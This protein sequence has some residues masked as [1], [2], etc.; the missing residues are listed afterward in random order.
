MAEQDATPAEEL[1]DLQIT[2][3]VGLGGGDALPLAAKP[4]W[5]VAQ[6]IHEAQALLKE[7]HAR[8]DVVHAGNVLPSD[9]TLEAAGL[10]DGSEV[11]LI[12]SRWQRGLR[13]RCLSSKR[14]PA[15]LGT[16]VGIFE[17]VPQIILDKSLLVP[18]TLEDFLTVEPTGETVPT[19]QE[20]VTKATKDLTGVNG[21]TSVDDDAPVRIREVSLGEC[22]R[23]RSPDLPSAS[24]EGW[25]T[26]MVKG[27]HPVRL[28]DAQDKFEFDATGFIYDQI[29]DDDGKEARVFIWD[30]HKGTADDLEVLELLTDSD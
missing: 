17:N 30:M 16:I 4:L 26:C 5:T 1:P 27:L 11:N 15:S 21:E 24:I 22:V 10:A 3:V 14:Q 20:V 18:F 7:E 29:V 13:V 23:C 19:T 28:A 12:R 6:L 25:K 2:V 9:S 8:A